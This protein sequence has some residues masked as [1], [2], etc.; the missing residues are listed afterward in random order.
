M[1]IFD[2]KDKVKRKIKTTSFFN[3]KFGFESGIDITDDN[4]V[5]YRKNVV[6]KNIILVSNVLFTILF[7]LVSLGSSDNSSYK[8]V[9]TIILFPITYVVN[10]WLKA[11][12]KRGPDDKLSQ[13]AAMYFASF[14]MFVIT[15][16]I[17]FKLS[18]GGQKYL[19][20]CG[21]ILI[22]YSLL[23]TG[24]YQDKKL[25]KNVYLVLFILITILHFTVTYDVL[26]S[27]KGKDLLSFIT[28]FVSSNDFK[29]IVLR[30]LLLALFSA[31]L[32][33]YVSMAIYMQEER[34]KELIKRRRVQE[35]FTNVVTKIFDVTLSDSI[36]L[37][38][39]ERRNITII[40][41]MTEKLAS[42][43][44]FDTKKIKALVEFS[45]IHMDRSVSFDNSNITNEDLKFENLRLQTEL[46]STLI[47]R[48]HLTRKSEEIVRSVLEGSDSPEFITKTRDAISDVDFQI[49]LIC[50][51]YVTLRGVKSYKKAINHKK[52]MEYFDSKFKIF[53]DPVVYDRFFRF[54]SDFETI[55][56]E[57]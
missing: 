38:E 43:L 25:L 32:Y 37:D 34:K 20:T 12:L 16:I 13:I 15:T 51:I 9:L 5:L 7:T 39:E 44:S 53:F 49:V 1:G 36:S 42:I 33:I 56:D 57:N 8:W 47:S 3:D 22:Y 6:I 2:L 23:I 41:I 14:Y 48:L 10:R 31:V 18:F 21:Y 40:S 55:Y 50:E 28:S 29:D 45:K 52:V 17:Y 54:N 30:T 24:F 27:A 26:G 19:E 46:G 4:Q 11:L 35:D